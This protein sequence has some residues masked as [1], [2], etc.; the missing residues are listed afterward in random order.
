MENELRTTNRLGAPLEWEKINDEHIAYD[1][2]GY[3]AGKVS[4]KDKE[5]ISVHSL[6]SI[7]WVL[8]EK[9]TFRNLGT[10]KS[11]SDAKKMIQLHERCETIPIFEP[12]KLVGWE[13]K[14]GKI[15]L[16]THK[17]QKSLISRI[18]SRLCSTFK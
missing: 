11:L 15:K 10:Y 9:T 12:G 18:W 14:A 2:N 16:A 5:F 3:P 13:D 6:P 4:I 8:G 7:R 17:E 1:P